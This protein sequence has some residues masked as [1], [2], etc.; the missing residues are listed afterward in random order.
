MEGRRAAQ[1]RDTAGRQET[2]DRAFGEGGNGSGCGVGR[3]S[4]FVIDNGDTLGKE[5]VEAVLTC[6]TVNTI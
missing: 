4:C 3:Q 6:I 5:K 1:H 2:R